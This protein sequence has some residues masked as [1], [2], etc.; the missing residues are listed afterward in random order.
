MDPG[1]TEYRRVTVECALGN[2]RWHDAFAYIFYL[3]GSLIR[4]PLQRGPMSNLH[5]DKEDICA[6]S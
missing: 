6:S 5:N 2:L 1:L 4:L 3:I